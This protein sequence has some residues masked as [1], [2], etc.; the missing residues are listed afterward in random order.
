MPDRSSL[1]V[2]AHEHLRRDEMLGQIV[3][4]NGPIGLVPADDVFRRISQ[5]VVRQQISMAAADAIFERLAD[6]VDLTPASLRAI[7][8]EELQQ[9][10]L[11]TAKAT[12]LRELAIA[13]E[14]REWSRSHFESMDSSTVIET[15]TEVHGIGPWTAKMALIFGFGR[16]NIWPV[17]DLG[18]RRSMRDL[19]ESEMTRSACVACANDWSPYRSF[20]ALHLWKR[21]DG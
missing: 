14:E 17:E 1:A 13:W 18:I 7:P 15:I 9:F 3:E 10:G 11:S 20:A 12:T 16:A 5:S 8:P 19:F 4:H 21:Q 6:N 2:S